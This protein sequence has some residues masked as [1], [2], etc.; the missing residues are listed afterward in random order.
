MPSSHTARKRE[1]FLSLDVLLSPFT[2]KGVEFQNRI[3]STSHA[4]GYGENGMPG[5]RYQRY[6]EEKAKGGIALTMFG[7]SS[8]VAP[9]V[10]AIYNQLD[11]GT[12]AIIPHFQA[13][14]QRI[15]HH[16]TR[17]M[18]QISHM[19]RRTSGE[20]GDWIAP[21]APSSVRDPAHHA[22]PRAMEIEDIDRIVSSYGDAALRCAEGNLDGCEVFVPSHLPG[23]FLA[24]NANFRTD[25]YGGS[26]ENRMR[27]LRRVL[28]NIR[29]KT[30]SGFLVSLRMAVDESQE[31]GPDRAECLTVARTLY[32]ADLYDILNLNGIAASTTWGISRVIG[33]M[34]VPLGSYLSDVAAF[35]AEVGAPVIHAGRIADLSTAAH[36]IESGAVDLVGMTRAHMADPYIVHKL[37]KGQ[38]DRIRPCVG[39]AYCIDRIYAGRAAFCLHN[40]ATGRETTLPQKIKVSSGPRRKIVVV[41]GG[42]AGLEAARVAAHRGHEVV[43]FE[44]GSR[45]GGQLLIASRIGWRRDLIGIVD[46]LQSEIERLKVDIRYNCYAEADGILAEVPDIVIVATGGTPRSPAIDGAEH[47]MSSWDAAT[48]PGEFE[49]ALIYDED[50]GHAAISLAQQIA[51]QGRKVVI[52]TNDRILGRSLGGSSYPVYLGALAEAG[53]RII[54]DYRLVSIA[55]RGNRL[56]ATLAHDFGS[57]REE[58]TV[59]RVIVEL[60]SEPADQLFHDLKPH[61]RNRGVTDVDALKNSTPQPWLQDGENGL[62]L[63]RVGDAVSSRDTHAAMLDSLRILKDA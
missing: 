11:V 17:L 4:P 46:W 51:T 63:F 49:T 60:G 40:P 2:V 21:I 45:L 48:Q 57:A 52:A 5:E 62:L 34:S 10:S 33:G 27:F 6:H 7:G 9:E 38:P 29:A 37:M 53:A 36:A 22:V 28:E 23:Q 31:G 3:V 47:A 26:L 54:T 16:G 19:G 42:P 32:E 58:L 18:C 43:L 24:P 50:G 14:A 12:D 25:D 20:D 1:A 15:H 39:A 61:A 35:R 55:K 41:G 13:F 44:A 30:P 8:I 59:D 56:S